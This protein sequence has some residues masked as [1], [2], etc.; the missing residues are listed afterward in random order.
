[1]TY[2]MRGLTFDQ[3]RVGMRFVT[4]AR[5]ITETDVVNFAGFSGDFNALHTNEEHARSTPYGTRIAHGMLGAAISSG[6]ANRL[7][8][9]EG[10]VIALRFQSMKYKRP[11]HIGDTV[12]LEMEVTEVKGN[13]HGSRGTVVF[14]TRLVNQDEKLVIDGQWNLLVRGGERP[15]GERG[16]EASRESRPEGGAEEPT[17]QGVSLFVDPITPPPRT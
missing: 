5:T 8:I 7:G 4:A 16:E 11:L 3:Y 1:M 12:H 6:L 10:T 2:L 15:R 13:C 9:F 17:E 14:E